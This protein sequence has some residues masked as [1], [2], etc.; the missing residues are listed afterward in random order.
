MRPQLSWMPLLRN[1]L[2]SGNRNSKIMQMGL[3]Q[4]QGMYASIGLFFFFLPPLTS[5]ELLPFPL[6]NRLIDTYGQTLFIA[7]ESDHNKEIYP[8]TSVCVWI[9]SLQ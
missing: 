2:S 1:S 8:N 7:G 9:K 6:S 3:G 4:E 5:T